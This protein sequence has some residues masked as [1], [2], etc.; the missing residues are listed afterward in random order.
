MSSQPQKKRV[1]QDHNF[2]LLMPYSFSYH[3]WGL[4]LKKKNLEIELILKSCE[5]VL[6]Q[7]P[8]SPVCLT[9]ELSVL[10]DFKL[11]EQ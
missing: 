11:A 10:Q 4:L 5:D 3:T 1:K 6:L 9:L 8:G 7:E 2:I